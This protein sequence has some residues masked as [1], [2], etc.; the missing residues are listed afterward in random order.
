[1]PLL[2]LAPARAARLAAAATSAN[3]SAE[4][5]SSPSASRIAVRVRLDPVSPSGTGK[6]FRSFRLGAAGFDRGR[7]PAGRGQGDL[8]RAIHGRWVTECA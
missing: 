1:M 4:P 3:D 8:A 2:P 7:A 5:D 6:T